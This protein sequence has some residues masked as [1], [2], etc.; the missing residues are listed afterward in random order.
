MK[1]S[2]PLTSTTRQLKEVGETRDENDNTSTTGSPVTTY[3]STGRL[4]YLFLI[5]YTIGKCYLHL[6]V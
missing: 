2:L 4:K 3:T 6:K 5:I 1:P